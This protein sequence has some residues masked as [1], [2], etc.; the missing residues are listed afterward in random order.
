MIDPLKITKEDCPLIVLSA[1]S[2][3]WISFLIKWWTN[4]NVSHAMWL[5]DNN[6]VASQ[7]L[8]FD[9][10]PLTE[11]MVE[12]GHLEFWRPLFTED[13]REKLFNIIN[14][15]LHKPKIKTRYDWIG[16]I[17]QIIKWD[18]FNNPRTTFC[19]EKI[20]EHLMKFNLFKLLKKEMNISEHPSPKKLKTF[21][22]QFPKLFE[23]VGIWVSI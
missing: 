13:N 6:L 2:F 4:S 1:H 21:M 23:L 5:I 17:G 22:I 19:S 20:M 16:I 14:A 12:G 3:D 7:D 15:D 9:T 10:K 8:F 11:Y 18:D